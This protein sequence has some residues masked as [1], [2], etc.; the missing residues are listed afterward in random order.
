MIIDGGHTHNMWAGKFVKIYT[1][2]EDTGK[3]RVSGSGRRYKDN[4]RV[5]AYGTIDEAGALLGVT[6]S[7]LG[8]S[9]EIF[10]KFW[11]MCNRYFGISEQTWLV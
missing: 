4:V 11:A 1:R 10:E 3:T 9:M 7:M 8:G 5:Q 2:H 6:M